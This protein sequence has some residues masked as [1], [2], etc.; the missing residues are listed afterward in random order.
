L[1]MPPLGLAYL[2][3]VLLK[4]N[5]QVQVIDAHLLNIRSENIADAF[6][7]Q[8]DIVGIST[9]IVSYHEAARCAERVKSI[10]AEVPILFGGPYS[11]SLAKVILKK[12]SAVDAV[13]INEGEET[14]AEIAGSL[15]KNNIFENVQGVAYR[16]KDRIIRNEPRALIKNLDDIPIPAY[17]CLP[18]LRKYKSRS[19]AEP[20]GYI[21][22][23]RGCP[24]RCTFCYRSFGTFWRP[25]SANRVVEEICYLVKEYGIRQVDILDDNFTF[26]ID[27]TMAILDLL[28][29]RS[30]KIAINLQIGVRVDR[31]NEALLMRMK[32]AGVF[33]IGFGIESGDDNILK[34]AK[35]DLN[36]DKA[37]SLTKF[38]RSLGMI[39]HGFFII[40]LPGESAQSAMKTIDFSLKMNPHYASFSVCVPL[41]GTEIF[42]E[43]K[44]KGQILVDVENGMETG[45]FSLKPFFKLDAMSSQETASYNEMAWRKFYLRPSK[46]IDVLSTIK[47]MGEL[48]WLMRIIN[49]S[50]KVKFK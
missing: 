23:S 41:P 15:G 49:E 48:K 50:L 33:K 24:S 4:N 40:G 7:F 37:I 26:D 38:A 11:S 31:V 47:S 36:L 22:T 13:V 6:S 18:D 46:I 3:A 39:T 28:E 20:V 45:F 32:K 19:R 5:H 1:T 2:A 34:R 42:D 14:L 12:N 30:L 17:Q 27:R 43:I 10:Y 44:Q 21:I 29:K 8:P 25:H 16:T 9:N 35:K